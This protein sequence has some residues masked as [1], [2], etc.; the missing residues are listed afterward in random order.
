[1]AKKIDKTEDGMQAVE[2]ALS[3]TEKFIE[4]NQKILTIVVGALVV[5]ILGYFGYTRLYVQPLEEEANAQLFQAEIYFQQDSLNKALYGDGNALGFIDISDEF[6]VTKAGKLA[7]YYAGICYLHLGEFENAIDYLKD[8]SLSD[9]IVAPMALGA[10]GDAYMELQDLDAA[11]KYYVNAAKADKNEFTAPTFY[12][13]AGMTYE[14]LENYGKALDMYQA[15]K[16]DFGAS[17]EAR[18]IEKTITRLEL[19]SK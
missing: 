11:A 19:L 15:I 4:A 17:I 3:K 9:H 16:K 8:F 13:K 1:M 7:N 10:I 5:I 2:Q 14:M 18:D 12:L 6:G